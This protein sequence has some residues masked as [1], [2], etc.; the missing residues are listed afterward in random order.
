M[1]RNTKS[2]A[3]MTKP[4]AMKMPWTLKRS[5]EPLADAVEGVPAISGKAALHLWQISC[6]G[7]TRMLH[8]GQK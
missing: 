6:W 5:L 7:A 1:K 3:T 2:R 8:W 4:V